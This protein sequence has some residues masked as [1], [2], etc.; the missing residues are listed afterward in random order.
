MSAPVFKAL[1]HFL[2]RYPHNEPLQQISQKLLAPSPLNSVEDIG[3]AIRNYQDTIPLIESEMWSTI[4]DDEQLSRHQQLYQ[5][6]EQLVTLKGDDQRHQF[7]IT[8]PVADRPQ[9]LQGCLESLLT[10]CNKFQYGGKVDGKY[11]RLKVLIADD[12]KAHESISR[13]REIADEFSSAGIE[14]IYFGISEQLQQLD[15]LSDQQ[16]DSLQHVLGNLDRDHFYHKGASIMRNLAYLKLQQLTQVSP[17]K[18]NTL[19]YFIDSDQEFKV[20]VQTTDGD[21]DIY[22]FSFLHALDQIFNQRSVE[23]LTGKVVGDPPVSPSVMAGNFLEDVIAF[24]HQMAEIDSDAPCRFHHLEQQKVD[25]ASY[26]DMAELFGFKPSVE[27]YNYNCTLANT[28]SHVDCFNDFARKLNH[29]FDGEHPTRKSY[30]EYADPLTSVI[31]ARTI[32]TGNY[33]FRQ[34]AF[35]YFIPFATLKLRMAGP[36]LGRI[37]KSEIDGQFVSAN[38]PMLHKRTVDEIGESEFRAGVERSEQHIDLADEFERQFFGDVMLFTMQQ[39]TTMGYPHKKLAKQVIQDTVHTIENE[40]HEKYQHKQIAISNKVASLKKIFNEPAAWW[41]TA[42]NTASA[43]ASF[44]QFIGN[45]EH[46]FG[47]DARAYQLISSATHRQQRLDNIVDAIE[48]Y[49]DDRTSWKL[50]LQ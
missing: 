34:S 24:V 22:A 49:S 11:S 48:A 14:T 37:I 20:K 9:H 27:S 25:D 18:E 44:Q 28:H 6:L 31:P 13:N 23:I 3:Q 4:P 32:Y 35:D 47:D 17:E 30:Y 41:N 12:S 40:M 39:L 2:E 46:N 43:R 10:L 16:R 50:V 15:S 42:A 36:V 19:F 45:I 29:F 1:R 33:I 38:L 8:I 7:I 5:E 21:K 26:H